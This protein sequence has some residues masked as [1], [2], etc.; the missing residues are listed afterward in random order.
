MRCQNFVADG[1][2]TYIN[3][4]YDV[5]VFLKWCA[6][7]YKKALNLRRCFYKSLWRLEPDKII[8]KLIG[9]PGLGPGRFN[10]T[11]YRR[12]P[13]EIIQLRCNYRANIVQ[14]RTIS[15]THAWAWLNI[16]P[17][18]L[19]NVI[20]GVSFVAAPASFWLGRPV[21]FRTAFEPLNWVSMFVNTLSLQILIS[22][23]VSL[24]A[25][26]TSQQPAVVITDITQS[27]IGTGLPRYPPTAL[28]H[29]LMVESINCSTCD[30]NPSEVS[31]TIYALVA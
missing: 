10:Q 19:R 3:H 29:T 24:H 26:I 4:N 6:T 9:L 23:C 25:T 21:P 28:L 12:R 17:L 15:L 14:L 18:S 2:P 13:M 27:V 1:V 20:G 11:P 5:N 16:F 22:V 31:S 8:M 30:P 7:N